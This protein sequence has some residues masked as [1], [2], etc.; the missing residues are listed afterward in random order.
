MSASDATGLMSCIRGSGRRA[1]C[2]ARLREEFTMPVTS[3]W[4]SLLFAMI[5]MIV[6]F[7]G[8]LLPYLIISGSGSPREAFGVR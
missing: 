6:L 5:V 3:D 4:T 1:R 2:W 7:A 8:L